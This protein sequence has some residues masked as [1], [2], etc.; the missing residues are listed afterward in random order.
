MR[1]RVL[2]EEPVCKRCRREASTVADH[3]VSV[4]R[5]RE[6]GWTEAQIFARTNYQGLCG[7]CNSI[8][9]IEEEGGFGRA[10][11]RRTGTAPTSS[12]SVN[13]TSVTGRERRSDVR[14]R[15]VT[16]GGGSDLSRVHP[17]GPDKA[18]PCNAAKVRPNFAEGLR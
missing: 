14:P 15:R 7:P 2:R 8:K 12:E 4:K 11:K 9:G 1:E 3:K 13:A 6:L 16:R 5:A 17:S 10:P 18:T